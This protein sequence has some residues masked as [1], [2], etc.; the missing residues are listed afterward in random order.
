MD[1]LTKIY[2][3]T[4]LVIITSPLN[5]FPYVALEAKSFGI[6]VIS[7]SRGDI[8]RIVSN[9]IDGFVRHNYSKNR[10]QDFICKKLKMIIQKI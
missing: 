8:K 4:N 5:N 10:L 3:N 2:R 9:G 7:C 1:G 6:P